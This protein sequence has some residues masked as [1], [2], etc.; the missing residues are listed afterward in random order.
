MAEVTRQQYQDEVKKY[1]SER[2]KKLQTEN[3]KLKTTIQ[4]ALTS[5]AIMNMP[6]SGNPANVAT[7]DDLLKIMADSFREALK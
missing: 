6:V 1:W 5:L 4:N 7:N 2:C 3:E